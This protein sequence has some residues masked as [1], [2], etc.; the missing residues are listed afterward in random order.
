[1]LTYEQA[2]RVLATLP[3]LR[4]QFFLQEVY[5]AELIATQSTTPSRGYRAVNTLFPADETPDGRFGYTRNALI[6]GENT[7]TQRVFTGDLD[8]RLATIQTS[9]GG[10]IRIMGPGGRVLGGSVVRTAEQVNRRLSVV[11]LPGLRSSLDLFLSGQRIDAIPARFEGIITVRGG[12]LYSFTDGDFLL[13]QSR[14]FTVG[15]GDIALWSSN[16]DLN[17]GE[18][19]KST[20][21]FPAVIVACDL[22]GF[23]E[24]DQGAATTGAGIAGF[25]VR[26]R[27]AFETLRRLIRLEEAA[28]P[29]LAANPPA[30]LRNPDDPEGIITTRLPSDR[31]LALLGGATGAPGA[32]AAGETVF[33]ALGGNG[34]ALIVP[35]L[36]AALGLN[37]SLNPTPNVDLKALRGTV[38]AGAAG[39]RVA[40]NLNV[41][42]LRVLNAEQFQVGGVAIGLPQVTAPNVGGILQGSGAAAA[43]QQS[44]GP[45]QEA[46][47]QPSIIIVEVIGYGGGDPNEQPCPDG[48]PRVNGVCP[49]RQTSNP[50]QGYDYNSE[51]QVVRFG[52]R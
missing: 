32:G 34:E 1:M 17:A 2:Y 23:C 36:A 19:P 45:R 24:E 48:R 26:S 11:T 6:G 51:I 8:L 44:E 20:S 16:A 18:G 41:A 50:P 15:G 9:R 5:F 49:E 14:A 52:R 3:V 43:G 22:N 21:S 30:V 39:V 4:S 7:G 27:D 28:T 40:G 46:R 31:L 29:G 38:D 35:S 10:D 13:N 33:E 37:P 25:S 47:P 12:S 42:A